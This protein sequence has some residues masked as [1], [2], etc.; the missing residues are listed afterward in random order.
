M[1]NIDEKLALKIDKLIAQ[2]Y[3]KKG[4]EGYSTHDLNDIIEILIQNHTFTSKDSIND[5]MI[6]LE[7]MLD[8]SEV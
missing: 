4:Y 7:N 5:L 1:K 3:I 2:E 8:D 6:R